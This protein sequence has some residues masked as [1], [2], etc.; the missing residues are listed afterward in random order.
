MQDQPQ[1]TASPFVETCETL[2]V[3]TDVTRGVHVP[4][5]EEIAPLADLF[6][7]YADTTRLKIIMALSQAELCV[8]DLC[9]LIGMEQSAVSL[10]L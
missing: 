6:R 4:S 5:T 2:Q 10:H 1:N 3:H 7:A 9:S 8:C